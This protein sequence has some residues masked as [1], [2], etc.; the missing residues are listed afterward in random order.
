[1]KIKG[2]YKEGYVRYRIKIN[3]TWT[4]DLYTIFKTEMS[5]L[6]KI[7]NKLTQITN[8][9]DILKHCSSN[10]DILKHWSSDTLTTIALVYKD[11]VYHSHIRLPEVDMRLL[12]LNDPNNLII[13]GLFKS[14]CVSHRYYCSK[15][16]SK[17]K[18][19]RVRYK[20]L[21]MYEL[22]QNDYDYT[23]DIWI[24]KNKPIIREDVV[25]I[26]E[27]FYHDERRY[28]QHILTILWKLLYFNYIPKHYIETS[29]WWYKA[30]YRVIADYEDKGCD[31][32]DI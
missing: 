30:L 12:S 32:Y 27:T 8:N 6:S 3:K 14:Y 18:P 11:K 16:N 10:K 2:K 4:I 7:R 22:L 31:N 19:K 15:F 21:I 9:K 5:D 20:N 25:P 1:M 24:N 29:Y 28:F 13:Y 23:V 17:S 26:I